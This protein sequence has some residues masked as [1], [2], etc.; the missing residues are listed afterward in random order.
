RSR[1]ACAISPIAASAKIT[2]GM[3][4]RIQ[5]LARPSSCPPAEQRETPIAAHEHFSLAVQGLVTAAR[6]H[7][8]GAD[9]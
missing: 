7:L 6:A 1:R 9:G 2:A 3:A 5:R 4:R 8:N